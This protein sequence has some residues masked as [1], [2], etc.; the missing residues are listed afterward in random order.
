MLFILVALTAQLC[1]I[2]LSYV[3]CDVLAATMASRLGTGD[4]ATE[5]Q[6]LL[7]CQT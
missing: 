7:P 3:Q 6:K 5:R 4:T 2:S 1:T